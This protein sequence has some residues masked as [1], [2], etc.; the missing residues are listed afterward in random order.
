MYKIL[1]KISDHFLKLGKLGWGDHPLLLVLGSA[2]VWK[3]KASSP[4]T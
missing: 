4:F 2:H 3:K 1:K